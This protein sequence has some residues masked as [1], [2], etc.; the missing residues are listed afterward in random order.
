MD[1]S[2]PSMNAARRTSHIILASEERYMQVD[3]DG[4]TCRVLS[5]NIFGR[6]AAKISQ[7]IKSWLI[8]E[9]SLNRIC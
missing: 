1:V 6:I 3:T 5:R 8:S 7:K 2:I 9:R 4:Q